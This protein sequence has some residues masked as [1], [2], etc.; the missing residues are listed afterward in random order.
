MLTALSRMIFR[1]LSAKVRDSRDKGGTSA[2]V[3]AKA[4]TYPRVT[5]SAACLAR[6][7]EFLHFSE[8]KRAESV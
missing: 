6:T 4:R 1:E 7:I 8:S 3:R 5:F 2:N